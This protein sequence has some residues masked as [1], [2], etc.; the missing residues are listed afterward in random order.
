MDNHNSILEL[1]IKFDVPLEAVI[2]SDL[3][4]LGLS[5]SPEALKA[6]VIA[7]P[8]SYF[9]FSFDRV[10]QKEMSEMERQA[11]PE[12]IALIGGP[13]DL[14][15]TIVSVRVNP[16][17][18]YQIFADVGGSSALGS[19]FSEPAVPSPQAPATSRLRSR[20]TQEN[21]LEGGVGLR[22]LPQKNE[23]SASS[24]KLALKRNGELICFILLPLYPPYYSQPLKSGK[25]VSDI[26][27][28]IEWGYLVYLTAFR[29]CQYFGVEEECQ[30]CDINHNYRQ[31]KGV[32]RPY[33]GIKTP[34]EVVEALRIIFEMDTDRV[35]QAYTVSGGAVTKELNGMKEAEFYAQYARTIEDKFPGRWIGKAN[36]QALPLD[37]VKILKKA[38]YQI[39]HPNY[40]VWDPKLFSKLSP[41]KER[42]IGRDEWIKRTLDAAGV[43]GPENVIPNF[44]AGI[45]MSRPHGFDSI[46]EAIASTREGLEFFMSRGIFPRFTTWCVE[47]GTALTANNSEPPPLEYY[48]RL[49]QIYRDT[50][51][52]Y[53]LPYP[54]GYGEPGL[55]RAVFSVS[56]FMDIL[57]QG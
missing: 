18:P 8:K 29:L 27:P 21:R 52:K 53:G 10:S 19:F 55:G 38:G 45:E 16:R 42:Y 49:L 56:A 15:R 47:P 22:E 9:I 40:E 1:G 23:P 25:P 34:E 30:F 44:V 11:V 7:K 6:C 2:K 57:G 35:S 33:T 37:E 20:P 32:G 50:F 14:K 48:V 46:D 36:V 39:Y 24:I 28:T 5:F 13:Y 41:G 12:E 17:S 26:A 31:Q 43:F 54:K 3:L 4:R 51:R